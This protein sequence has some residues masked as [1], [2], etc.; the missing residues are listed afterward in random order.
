MAVALVIR[1]RNLIP[2][3]LADA[4]VLIASFQT[5]GAVSAGPLQS[6]PDDLYHFLILIQPNSHTIN[7]FFFDYTTVV[8]KIPLQTHPLYGIINVSNFGGSL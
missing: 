1:V 5:A 3:F 2:E 8:K 7:S 4:L 6:V